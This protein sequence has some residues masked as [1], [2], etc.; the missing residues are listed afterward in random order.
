MSFGGHPRTLGL[1]SVPW[2][3]SHTSHPGN[4]RWDQGRETEATS[5][6]TREKPVARPCLGPPTGSGEPHSPLCGKTKPGAAPVGTWA[7]PC[8]PPNTWTG[9]CNPSRDFGSACARPQDAPAHPRRASM[10][11]QTLSSSHSVPR[12]AWASAPASCGE[13]ALLR[14]GKGPCTAAP[15]ESGGRCPC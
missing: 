14:A 6:L 5:R 4:L 3:L 1:F 11:T 15:G 13:T 7:S 10:V 2:T 9:I 8:S 12:G